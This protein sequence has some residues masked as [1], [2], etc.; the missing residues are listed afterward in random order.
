MELVVLVC[1]ITTPG[2]CHEER[3]RFS[4]E[5]VT[6]RACMVAA[7]PFLA[8][9]SMAHPDWRVARWRCGIPGAE[10]YRI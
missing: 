7:P 5:P 8:Q 9:W 1:L 10:G 6:G 3:V 4:M 2:T